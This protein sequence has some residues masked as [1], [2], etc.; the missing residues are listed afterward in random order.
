MEPVAAPGKGRIA[1]PLGIYVITAFDGIFIG[2]VPLILLIVL[3]SDPGIKISEF[4]YYLTAVLRIVV[5]A[6]ALGALMGENLGRRILL[7]AVT[8]VSISMILNSVNLLSGSQ[9]AGAQGVGL[10]GN[11]TRGIF[12]TAINWWYFYRKGV[13]DYYKQNKEASPRQ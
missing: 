12:W 3:D 10:I 1:K 13:A 5:V 6:A 9:E 7:W 11:I 8:A 2:L 4:D